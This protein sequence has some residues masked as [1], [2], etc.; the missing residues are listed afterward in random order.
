MQESGGEFDIATAQYDSTTDTRLKGKPQIQDL[1]DFQKRQKEISDVRKSVETSSPLNKEVKKQTTS[2][3]KKAYDNE[4][5]SIEDEIKKIKQD[6]N[7][8]TERLKEFTFKIPSTTEIKDLYE[9]DTQ[10]GKQI[11]TGESVS[12]YQAAQNE[13]ENLREEDNKRYAELS[14]RYANLFVAKN[15]FELE[16]D[17]EVVAAT[18]EVI[19]NL[20][21]FF[22]VGM[23]LYGAAKMGVE[24]ILGSGAIGIATS[25]VGATQEEI[26]NASPEYREALLKAREQIK[27]EQTDM[28]K[29][30][31]NK[32]E[33]SAETSLQYGLAKGLEDV[34][35]PQD[36]LNFAVTSFGEQLPQ[37]AQ[38]II[39]LGYGTYIQELGSMQQEIVNSLMNE[40]GMTLEQALDSEEVK[41]IDQR[42]SAMEIAAL[43]LIGLATMGAGKIIKPLAK[44]STITKVLKPIQKATLGTVTEI[45][46]E[47]GQEAIAKGG[48]SSALGEGF[49][50]GFTSLTADEA[51]NVGA[52][53][54]FGSAPISSISAFT[55]KG[56]INQDMLNEASVNPKVRQMLTGVI[57]TR[58]TAGIISTEEANKQ[59]LDLNN[60]V[61]ANLQIPEDIQGEQRD[62]LVKLQKTYNELAEAKSNASPAFAPN[63]N[64]RMKSIEEQMQKVAS[65]PKQERTTV[66]Q[67]GDKKEIK[68]KPTTEEQLKD[69]KDG[70]VV[71]FTYENESQVPDVFK[72]KISSTGETNG[73]PFVKVTVARNLADYELSQQKQSE[74]TSDSDMSQVDKTGIQ[75]GEKEIEK[76]VSTLSSIQEKYPDVTLDVFESKKSGTI[77]LGKIE[78]PKAQRGEG[79][80]T[81]VMSD[82]IN[83]A[84]ANGL[85]ITLTPSNEFGASKARLKEFYKRFGFV[86][87]KGENRDFSHKD[88]MY[89]NPEVVVSESKETADGKKEI[90]EVK[91]GTHTSSNPI[92]IFKGLG[93][94]LDLNGMRINAHKGVKGVFATVDEGLAKEYAK[95]KGVSEIIIPE[96]TTF[97]VIEVDGAG[98]TPSQYR[99]A[100]VKAINNSKAD[101]VKLITVDGKIK[102]GTKKQEQYIIKNSEL[103]N[104]L[105]SKQTSKQEP[106]SGAKKP[107]QKQETATTATAEQKR[108]QAPRDVKKETEGLTEKEVAKQGVEE[109]VDAYKQKIKDVKAVLNDKI[110]DIKA[111]A[112]DKQKALRDVGKA[113][114]EFIDEAIPKGIKIPKSLAKRAARATTP[115]AVENISNAI[116]RYVDRSILSAKRKQVR[117]NQKKA[118]SKLKKT[119][120]YTN[121][122]RLVERFLATLNATPIESAELLD[123]INSSLEDIIN[124]P[125]A[126][127]RENDISKLTEEVSKYEPVK[128]E[129]KEDVESLLERVN[130]SDLTIKQRAIALSKL[131]TL[132]ESKRQES[133]DILDSEVAELEAKIEGASE[134]LSEDLKEEIKYLNFETDELLK[135][136]DTTDM[137]PEQIAM[138]KELMKAP[139]SNKYNKAS[140]LNDIAVELSFGYAPIRKMQEYITSMISEQNANKSVDM[141]DKQAKKRKTPFQEAASKSWARFVVPKILRIKGISSKS[142]RDIVYDLRLMS[143]ERWDDYFGL[144][145][146]K[147]ISKNV[148]SPMETSITKMNTEVTNSVND[149]FKLGV[150]PKD[151]RRKIVMAIT[152]GYWDM[153]KGG[154]N[155]WQTLLDDES[156]KI[157]D[158][159]RYKEL[160]KDYESMDKSKD[161]KID[162][163]KY[164][165][166]LTGKEKKAYDWIVKNNEKLL[167]KQRI[168]NERRGQ[169]FEP[170]DSRYY[171]PMKRQGTSLTIESDDSFVDNLFSMF[172]DGATKLK[173]DRGEART[174]GKIQDIN[175]D[176]YGLVADQI[177]QT[178]RDFYVTETVRQSVKT[179]SKIATRIQDQ[180]AKKFATAM[181]AGL[182]SGLA[183]EFSPAPDSG[184]RILNR[185][186]KWLYPYVLMGTRLLPEALAETIRSV[187]A[188]DIRK[189][190][191]A[192]MFRPYRAEIMEFTGSPFLSNIYFENFDYASRRSFNK[193]QIG[194][195]SESVETA[196]QKILS[197]PDSITFSAIWSPSFLKEFKKVSG[198]EFSMSE[199]K[200]DKQ[201]YLENNEK[202][203]KEASA[204]ADSETQAIKGSK[205]RFSQREAVRVLPDIVINFVEAVSG[206]KYGYADSASALGRL[207]TTL[208]NFAFLE[209]FNIGNN[210]RESIYRENKSRSR[211][212]SELFTGVL[213]GTVYTLTA[214]VV[215]NF[216][217]MKL[218]EMFGDDDD[219]EK[220]TQRLKDMLSVE[221]IKDAALSNALFLSTGKYGN[222]GK[223]AVLIT[224]GLYDKYLKN[225]MSKSDYKKAHEEL[226]EVTRGRYF[227]APIDV[228]GYKSDS[229]IINSLAPFVGRMMDILG[230]SVS[231][232]VEGVTKLKN[233]IV[234]DEKIEVVVALKLMNDVLKLFMFVSGT[235]LP[236][237]K[238]IDKVLKMANKEEKK[239]NSPYKPVPVEKQK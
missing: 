143:K 232:T 61:E 136:V 60:S 70:N 25:S 156:F 220:A 95:D 138:V 86:D 168:S 15:R 207:I 98:M 59:I 126:K 171:I 211:A 34:Q 189:Q 90:T 196:N 139:K 21:P 101:V 56:E 66:E 11:V 176:L 113:M 158:P 184:M 111:T 225:S 227:S 83:Y 17:E 204:F 181:V 6:Y 41:A 206:K 72:D 94:K 106:S 107:Q 144:G 116:E 236:L 157:Q 235:P 53:A 44:L 103:I 75:D 80:A 178:N 237:Q 161:G 55:E 152:Q 9:V 218:A 47:I 54:L 163:K 118:L 210:V 42:I 88:D 51:M 79:I 120:E 52:K 146:E 160:K 216:S 130:D 32:L 230:D 219:K 19:D 12:E 49:I 46:T 221:G 81:N 229:D 112:K 234:N 172:K 185:V 31:V 89:R 78:V 195:L 200:K 177:Y 27:S 37:Y 119:S 16:Q 8:K 151:S 170:I 50:K 193:S 105:K 4:M 131:N 190:P 224:L 137:S 48:V 7:T 33:Q 109:I 28:F 93:G 179:M 203:I 223:T 108:K 63:Y 149:L 71:T 132:L 87:N 77:S 22:G 30:G 238:D 122:E 36:L 202:A 187:G 96:G 18:K 213:S 169:K 150:M 100:E 133:E 154:E 147:P 85:K 76:D 159:K 145:K 201:S 82:L 212:L 129:V 14:K 239:G 40:R 20:P 199:Y 127:V 194:R 135:K 97:E 26:D 99:D 186:F 205:T 114:S 173:S 91:I 182:K 174:S 231:G 215:Y 214:G 191:K 104:E 117:D 92:K 166:E 155:Y 233:S 164:L 198:K 121:K 226:V 23:R 141:I 67:Y 197:F 128:K 217:Q 58:E 102:A 64:E 123:R 115:K 188:A 142:L 2:E 110:K 74:G 165:S 222:V 162:Y 57:K 5:S 69:I 38:G 153:Y 65:E 183:K 43:D 3:I 45:G 140:L 208:Q 35:S 39:T 148:I 175:M 180:D 10:D 209:Q 62:K 1:T 24:Q 228:G 192:L 167:D 124:N 73:K 84:D 13:L 134:V 29:F 68:S 125:I